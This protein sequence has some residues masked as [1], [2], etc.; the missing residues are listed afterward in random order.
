MGASMSAWTLP[1]RTRSCV[2]ALRVGLSVLTTGIA[3]AMVRRCSSFLAATRLTTPHTATIRAMTAR[4]HAKRLTPCKRALPV[5]SREESTINV[6]EDLRRRAFV[7]AA[8]HQG[9]HGGNKQQRSHR[10][11]YQAA[12]HGPAQRCVLLATFA[13]A[14]GHGYHADDH[15]QCGHQHGPESGKPGL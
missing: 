3:A 5:V 1:G 2:A 13:Q 14:G 6:S 12:D 8:M 11:E 15:R 7:H 9:E 10:S 4:I